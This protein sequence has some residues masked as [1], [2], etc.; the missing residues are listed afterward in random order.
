M[1]E[2]DPS[3]VICFGCVVGKGSQ[4]LGPQAPIMKDDRPRDVW[5]ERLLVNGSPLIL[6]ATSVRD[7]P[8]NRRGRRSTL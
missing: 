6:V 2:A 4:L 8:A 3:D 1:P 5:N 7:G